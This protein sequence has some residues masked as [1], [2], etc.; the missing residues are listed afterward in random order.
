MRAIQIL[1]RIRAALPPVR[2]PVLLA[3][4]NVADS[5]SKL[6]WRCSS[7]PS[8]T[9]LRLGVR[10][11]V[12]RLFGKLDCIV[13]RISGRRCPKPIR[14][15]ARDALAVQAPEV[16]KPSSGLIFESFNQVTLVF[17]GTYSHTAWPQ[18]VHQLPPKK[19]RGWAG[20]SHPR[21]PTAGDSKPA[22]GTCHD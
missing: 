1:M 2:Y 4:A 16:C 17:H 6:S 13:L 20:R 10:Q 8:L 21:A 19:P 5:A 9:L 12:N 3:Q 7:M 15:A 11:R 14:F 18:F 22:A